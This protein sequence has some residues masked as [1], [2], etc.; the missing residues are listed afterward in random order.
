[1]LIVRVLI[2]ICLLVSVADAQTWRS[3]GRYQRQHHSAPAP[4]PAPPPAPSPSPTPDPPGTGVTPPAAAA[5]Y[6]LAWSD[7]FSALNLSPSGSGA[8][9]W[10]RS[11]WWNS[12][13]PPTANI[14]VANGVLGLKWTRN[15]GGSET[16]ISTFA[17][18]A[19]QGHV[20]RYGYFEARMKWDVATGAWPA[21]WAIPAQAANGQQHTGELDFFEGEGA[22]RY[23]FFGTAHEW[24]EGRQLWVSNPNYFAAGSSADF[25]QWH[26]YGS[27]WTP[28]QI[29]WFLDGRL[30]GSSNLPAIF[31]QQNFF[32]VLSMQEGANWSPG[33]LSGVS[34]QDLN[35]YV[36]Y[37]RVWQP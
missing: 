29:S 1:M 22:D 28:G 11:Y 16:S 21:F 34:V 4:S 18:D 3:H 36:D 14:T 9:N 2:P 19:S 5:N 13:I 27:L 37:V 26:T 10:Y 30:L 23:T 35:L 17:H 31:D 6:R 12:Y 33:N 32:L 24:N 25:S 7:E 20:F 8:F 15:Q